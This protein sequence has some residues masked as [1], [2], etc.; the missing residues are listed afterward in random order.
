MSKS[1]V[2]VLQLCRQK[3]H[4]S[5]SHWGNYKNPEKSVSDN[6]ND[7]LMWIESL[8][9][10]Q[11]KRGNRNR[12]CLM[13][14]RARSFDEVGERASTCTGEFQPCTVLP[15]TRI[16]S[17]TYLLRSHFEWFLVSYD[18]LLWSHPCYYLKQC[19]YRSTGQYNHRGRNTP[20]RTKKSFV[21][22]L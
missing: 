19:T 4:T 8:Q 12:Q 21:C 18:Y 2:V 16:Y 11:R 3:G 13:R 5:F 7:W 14:C 9:F 1:N 6:V 22:T 17:K 20:V 10:L 15:C